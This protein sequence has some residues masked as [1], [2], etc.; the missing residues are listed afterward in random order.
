[1]NSPSEDVKK[2]AVC[3]SAHKDGGI[4][5]IRFFHSFSEAE[6]IW[7]GCRPRGAFKIEHP[8]IFNDFSIIIG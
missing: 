3:A 4:G 2:L 8:F 1:M 5:E 6:R 7:D